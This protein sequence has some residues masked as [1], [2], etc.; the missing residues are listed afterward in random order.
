MLSLLFVLSPSG[1][2]G[3]GVHKRRVEGT[4]GSAPASAGGNVQ[5]RCL[6]FQLRSFGRTHKR[7]TCAGTRDCDAR[8][9]PALSRL[10]LLC[11][12]SL[13]LSC[14]LGAH[15]HPRSPPPSP[16]SHML[17]RGMFKL[18][19]YSNPPSCCNTATQKTQDKTS[20]AT[21][22]ARNYAAARQARLH[23]CRG[24]H[25]SKGITGQQ[26]SQPL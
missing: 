13:C 20:H 26:G 18:T 1:C 7:Y 14:G 24:A 22:K 9:C 11:P 5:E 21:P 19:T 16:P 15:T 17:P 8:D 10:S 2:C 4:L 25:R 23:V 3:G 12:A 6:L